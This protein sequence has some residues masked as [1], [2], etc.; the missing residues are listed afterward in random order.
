M[1]AGLVHA[2]QMALGGEGHRDLAV[3]GLFPFEPAFGKTFIGIVECEAPSAAQVDPALPA[4]LGAGM[5]V[6][7]GDRLSHVSSAQYRPLMN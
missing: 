3:E 7:W 1:K 2:G 5:E 6:G 4:Q